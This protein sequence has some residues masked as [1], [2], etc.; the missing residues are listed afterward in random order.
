MC[1]LMH[2]CGVFI[3]EVRV[4]NPFFLPFFPDGCAAQIGEGGKPVPFR[5]NPWGKL[6]QV[7]RYSWY[8]LISPSSWQPS[9]HLCPRGG[10]VQL[11][12]GHPTSHPASGVSAH[13][14]WLEG[15]LVTLKT[16]K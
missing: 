5:A 16:P 13:R 8:Q 2:A 6:T 11:P 14:A 4:W 3:C 9:L 1:T 15:V 10:L 7:G 12:H